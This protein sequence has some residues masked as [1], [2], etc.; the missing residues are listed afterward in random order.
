[1]GRDEVKRGKAS[2]KSGYELEPKFCLS[3]RRYDTDDSTYV[4]FAPQGLPVV[5]AGLL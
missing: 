4:L 1:M 3:Q 5:T 2:V